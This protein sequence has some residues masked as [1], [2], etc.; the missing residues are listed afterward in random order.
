MFQA[1]RQTTLRQAALRHAEL[2]YHTA[3]RALRK[4]SANALTGLLKNVMQTVVVLAAFF[5][6]MTFTGLKGVTIRGD[7]MLYLMSGVFL[8]IT[9]TRTVSAIVTSEGPG[10]AMMKHAPMN[11]MI[12]I[13]G[14]A[15]AALYIQ[16]LSMLLILGLYHLAWTPVTIDHPA[17]AM[18]M[19]LLAW[20]SG[21]GV[22]MVFVALKP[23][24]PGATTLLTNIWS[25]L[26]MVASGKMFVANQMPV[27]VLAFFTWNPLFHII[28][29][30]RGFIFINYE[31]HHSNVVYPA[32]VSLGLLFVGIMAEHHARKRAS[33][34]S[35]ATK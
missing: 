1:I 14:A 29:Q 26:N 9:H 24:A 17:G 10:A 2:S 6:L 13:C 3:V 22:G 23:S 19:F 8:F 4:D 25:R 30:A 7:F 34:S 31:P 15:V 16:L 21:V 35:Q 5:V 28:D 20:V 12:A 27:R 18:A 11:T 33:L 32:C